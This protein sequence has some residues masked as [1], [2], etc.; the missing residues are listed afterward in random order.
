[1]A[2]AGAGGLRG[3]Q[4]QGNPAVVAAVGKPGGTDR[5]DE[6]PGVGSGQDAR[7]AGAVVRRRRGAEDGA[8]PGRAGDGQPERLQAAQP[9][10]PRPQGRRSAAGGGGGRGGEVSL[11]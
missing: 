3:P 7:A 9:D 5:G 10:P 8:G 6:G 2:R 11:Y 4:V 1:G